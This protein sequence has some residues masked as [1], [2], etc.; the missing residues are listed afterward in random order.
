MER[1]YINR[2]ACGII[3]G[4]A[5]GTK[6]EDNSDIYN[7]IKKYRDVVNYSSAMSI[8]EKGSIFIYLRSTY[9]EIKNEAYEYIHVI[10]ESRKLTKLSE[11]E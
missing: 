8:I 5:Y 7:I 11:R 1:V 10:D 4:V 6:K 3:C 2:I 9:E